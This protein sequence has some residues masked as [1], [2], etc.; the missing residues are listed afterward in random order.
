MISLS[1]QEGSAMLSQPH[2]NLQ[3][4]KICDYCHKINHTREN[5]W[6]DLHGKPARG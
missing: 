6:I 3:S 2:I 1:V 4:N 5:C